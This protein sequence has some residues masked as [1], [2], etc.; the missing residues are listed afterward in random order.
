MRGSPLI[1]VLNPSA[2][3]VETIQEND[4]FISGDLN[5]KT[6]TNSRLALAKALNRDTENTIASIDARQAWEAS[7]NAPKKTTPFSQTLKATIL[8]TPVANY[9]ARIING[10][11]AVDASNPNYDPYPEIKGTEYEQ[12]WEYF[13]NA[14]GPTDVVRFKKQIDRESSVRD[15]LASSSIVAQLTAGVLTLPLD[16]INFIPVAGSAYRATKT[17]RFLA[18]AANTAAS[19]A[20][21]AG[22]SEAVLQATQITRTPEESV[23]NIAAGT[24][25]A[26]ILGGA[27]SLLSK[28]KF[29]ELADKVQKDIQDES[30]DYYF[31]A[32]GNIVQ[33]GGESLS[34][35][36]TP[37]PRALQTT[38]AEEGIYKGPLN[39][40]GGYNASTKFSPNQRVL[41]SDSVVAKR[42][43]QGL[44]RQNLYSPKNLEG[45]ANA[46]SVE[47]NLKLY[48]A[49]LATALKESRNNYKKFRDSLI[50]Q[51]GNPLSLLNPKAADTRL[52][53]YN[54][55]VYDALISGDTHI[56]PEIEASAKVFRDQVFEPLKKEAI[57]VG[58]LDEDVSIENATS[59][60]MIQYDK[61]RIVA[62]EPEFRK[63]IAQ[64]VK[65]T[66]VPSI[67]KEH[68]TKMATLANRSQEAYQRVK[69]LEEELAR[70]KASNTKAAKGKLSAKG[71][72]ETL[73]K[74]AAGDTAL[75]DEELL[76]VLDSYKAA[77][78]TLREETKPLA[79]SDFI[80]ARGGVFD[81]SG[82][83][84]KIFNSRNRLS[85]GIS[86][87]EKLSDV[88]GEKVNTD[89]KTFIDTAWREGYFPEYDAP[90]KTMEFLSIL[91]DELD[92]VETRFSMKDLDQADKIQQAKEFL[93]QVGDFG[94]DIGKIRDAKTLRETQIG[95]KSFRDILISREISALK[96]K[97]KTLDDKATL[98][99]Q[100]FESNV[101]DS[102]DEFANTIAA[103]ITRKIIGFDN[104]KGSL[105]YDL[106][107]GVRGPA[108]ERTLNFIQQSKLK[109]WL[110]TDIEKLARDYTRVM[111]TDVQL[112]KQ[113]GDLNL[114][115]VLANVSE[116]YE[117][118]RAK[119]TTEKERTKLKSQEDSVKND[120]V[121][122]K[123]VVRGSYGQ[124]A[125][126]DAFIPTATRNFR[127]FNYL[128][129]MG[130]VV[131]ASVVDT[132]NIVLKHGLT[133][134]MKDGV[135]PLITNIKGYKLVGKDT[136]FIGNASEVILRSRVN[137]LGDLSNPYST[138][139]SFENFVGA[140]T[141]NFSK[142]NM[143]SQWTDF[144]KNL[145][146]M[147]IQKRVATEIGNLVDNKITNKNKAYLALLGIDERNAKKIYNQIKKHRTV[148]EGL[149]ILNL[150]KWGDRDAF[151][152]M[153]NALNLDID[154]TIVT[155]GAGEIPLAFRSEVGKTLF[156]FKS[157]LVAANQQITIASMQQADAA[158]VS[159]IVTLVT[160]G[161]F[162]Y[163]MQ[164][165]IRGE[166]LSDNPIDWIVEGIDRSG[167][168]TVLSE[169]NG[170]ADI[171]GVG[172]R[173]AT[174]A[175]QASRTKGQ[176]VVSR[177]GGPTV[178]SFMDATDVTVATAKKT[179][180]DHTFTEAEQRKAIKL[181]MYNNLFY[182][183]GPLE[184]LNKSLNK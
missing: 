60:L 153:A 45:I 183:R 69:I 91:E 82:R 44:V 41:S 83:L 90:P 172:V 107:I 4:N 135:I 139:S 112:Q 138:K 12:H 122:L 35:A 132:G 58:I 70:V 52:K 67:Q 68:E 119:A 31:D 99:R 25:L 161:M 65:D 104:I 38:S 109:P 131:L 170:Y 63:F 80:R 155:P 10:E 110:V 179:F 174:G 66:L 11:Y 137:M 134:F 92:G 14:N 8:D 115:K 56:L 21:G 166:E 95:G 154:R 34:A 118:L 19:G 165:I 143:L 62:Q 168:V 15:T 94:I 114:E 64:E 123:D 113:F 167:L 76:R 171:L 164:K 159:G 146:S 130:A 126:P 125:N 49:G 13:L 46:A 29:D 127:N 129:K 133:R 144:S 43:I 3:A 54:S 182:V 7:I 73:F 87:K 75:N 120:L 106:K 85:K 23:A 9:V 72:S 6:S 40:A 16:P 33:Q 148:E 2:N 32:D 53:E 74:Q 84:E 140:L 175:R 158:V 181:L 17:G 20:L 79:L 101:G 162:V 22:L 97:I 28:Q 27:G 150:N 39:I 178:S 47:N 116:E 26:G 89:M 151:E 105:P 156:Q 93:N 71:K 48:D 157:F 77:A 1:P 169:V 121:S 184:Y 30:P 149:P 163:A 86:A 55:K 42:A 5:L 177:M 51:G 81:K 180:G 136:K 36:V 142:L 37:V 88:N 96:N 61:G 145:A 103:D 100:R 152:A 102:P 176:A 124:S 160:M 108:K 59:Y 111:G 50:E 98:R 24:V 141:Q 18:G 78:K 57:E 147:V 128:T 117:L 173:N